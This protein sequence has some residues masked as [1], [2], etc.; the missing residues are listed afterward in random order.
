MKM[1][2]WALVL[3]VSWLAPSARA[4]VKPHALCSEG[5]V[6]QQKETAHVW[7]TANK[8]EA[9]TVTFRGASAKARRTPTATGS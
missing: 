2:G 6:L 3:C 4:D 7:G 1:R 9:V 5:M 8:G